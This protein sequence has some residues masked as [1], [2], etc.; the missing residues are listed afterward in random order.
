M[1]PVGDKLW[2][3]GLPDGDAAPVLLAPRWP[4]RGGRAGTL[5]PSPGH[6][7]TTRREYTVAVQSTGRR[8]RSLPAVRQAM[9]LAVGLGAGPG[10]SV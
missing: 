3:G 4:S 2:R 1:R 5:P 6:G 10:S 9:V 8:V 7:T